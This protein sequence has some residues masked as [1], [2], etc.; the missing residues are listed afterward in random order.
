MIKYIIIL[1]NAIRPKGLFVYPGPWTKTSLSNFYFSFLLNKLII[2]NN[3]TFLFCNYLL[4]CLT[5][6]C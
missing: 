1:G 3:L 4:V 2:D 6:I 5:A